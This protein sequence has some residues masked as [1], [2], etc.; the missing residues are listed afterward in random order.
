MSRKTANTRTDI[1][2][3][4]TDRI[5]ADLERACAHG[6]SRGVRPIYRAG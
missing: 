3:R 2:A 1:Y 5:V 4:I 6:C